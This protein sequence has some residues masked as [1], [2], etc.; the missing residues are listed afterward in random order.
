MVDVNVRRRPRRY[1]GR[2]MMANVLAV[3]PAAVDRTRADAEKI[4]RIQQAIER[5]REIVGAVRATRTRSAELI[6][7][8]KAMAANYSR[9]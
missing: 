7:Q 5:C 4:A 3:S 1:A 6:A 8:A 2:I 9:G